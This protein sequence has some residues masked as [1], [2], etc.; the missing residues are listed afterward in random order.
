LVEVRKE[1][2]GVGR[3]RR[4]VTRKEQ[5]ERPGRAGGSKGGRPPR[6]ARLGP[7]GGETTVTPGGLTRISA[8]LDGRERDAVRRKAFEDDRSISDVIRSALRFYLGID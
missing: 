3:K 8:Y 6:R 1:I 4:V 2:A 5:S 7:R